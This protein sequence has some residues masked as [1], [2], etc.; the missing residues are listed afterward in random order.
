[1]LVADPGVGGRAVVLAM[2][3]PRGVRLWTQRQS[4]WYAVDGPRGHLTSAIEMEG[5]LTYVATRDDAGEVALWVRRRTATETSR[6]AYR[7]QP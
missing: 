5:G 7:A 6:P 3:T 4:G 1:V 2:Q